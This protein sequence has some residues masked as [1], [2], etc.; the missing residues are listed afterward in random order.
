MLTGNLN[1]LRAGTTS[2]NCDIAQF[3][4]PVLVQYSPYICPSI[5]PSSATSLG[6]GRGGSRLN[7]V[8]EARFLAPLGGSWWVPGP[9]KI[10]NLYSEF[11]SVPG[12]TPSSC[13][14]NLYR[15]LSMRM[16]RGSALGVWASYPVSKAE[17]SHPTEEA[18]FKSPVAVISFFRSLTT[19]HDHGRRLERAVDG[20][21][22][23]P[24]H[25]DGPVQGP[26]YCLSIS[27]STFPSLVNKTPRYYS[28]LTQKL[29][30]SSA[31]R[32][33]MDFAVKAVDISFP[34]VWNA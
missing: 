26:Q 1:L 6:L 11:W 9:D 33:R 32:P 31:H 25:H 30:A 10:Y 16:S 34:A 14:N 3:W 23:L 7:R 13:L 29:K 18:H 5:H 8:A 21:S 19:A 22:S 24:L 28:G 15:L 2:I 27:R 17:P 12:S 4:K 20:L